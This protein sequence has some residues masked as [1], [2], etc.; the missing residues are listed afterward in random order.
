MLKLDLGGKRQYDGLE[1]HVHP[2]GEEEIFNELQQ[3]KS[4]CKAVFT[5]YRH[6]LLVL[7]DE[8]DMPSRTQTFFLTKSL[9]P[10][11]FDD[12]KSLSIAFL[13]ILDQ[14]STLIFFNFFFYKM[15]ASNTFDRISRHFRSIHNF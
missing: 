7:L 14:Y 1:V 3:S 10:A 15:A 2:Y 8:V 5:R 4:R 13:A 9:T 11:I 12:Q 6:Q